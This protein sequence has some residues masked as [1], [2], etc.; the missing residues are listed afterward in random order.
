MMCSY[1]G[2]K[3]AECTV[4]GSSALPGGC[5]EPLGGPYPLGSGCPWRPR[6]GPGGG[7]KEAEEEGA[8]EHEAP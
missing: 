3:P 5:R 4:N 7:K 2:V 6:R 8:L 1:C